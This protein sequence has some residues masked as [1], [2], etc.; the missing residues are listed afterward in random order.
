MAVLLLLLQMLAVC[1]RLLI[2]MADCS[3]WQSAN[4]CGGAHT[5][6]RTASIGIRVEPP[7]K[8]AAEKAA[9]DDRRTLASFMEKLLVEW[10]EA[11][12][13]LPKAA[14]K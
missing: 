13:Y 14:A 6:A 8:A 7:I 9:N 3:Q 11:K 5:M 4:K 1:G 12:G 2:L 10:L